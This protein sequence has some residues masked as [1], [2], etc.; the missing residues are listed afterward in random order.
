MSTPNSDPSS[1]VWLLAD[2]PPVRRPGIIPLDA[3]HPS[4][5]NI[6]TPLLDEIQEVAWQFGRRLDRTKP[7]ILNAVQRAQDWQN[8]ELLDRQ[9]ENFSNTVKKHQP[10]L[11]FCFGQKSYEFAL[12]AV[13]ASVASG[14]DPTRWDFE[15]LGT[16]FRKSVIE[17]DPDTADGRP[18]LIP[19][20]HVSIAR[21]SY[22]DAHERFTGDEF[23]NYFA[24]AGAQLGQTLCRLTGK[25]DMMWLSRGDRT[26]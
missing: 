23:G 26:I 12:H 18:N 14:W 17:F 19:L 21:K 16:A 20:L 24:F 1:P 2:S 25:F 8:R 4:R 11:I 9:I 3:R 22:S 5:H 7:Y 10:T 15:K 13:N 6:W